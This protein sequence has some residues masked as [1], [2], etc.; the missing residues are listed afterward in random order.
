[1]AQ[2][3][4]LEAWASPTHHGPIVQTRATQ[5]QYIFRETGALLFYR[6]TMTPADDLG[7]TDVG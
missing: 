4:G 1:M 5:V 2:D 3:V 7:G 6:L